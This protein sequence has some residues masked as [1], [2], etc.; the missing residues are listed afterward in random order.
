MREAAEAGA[1]AANV[2]APTSR[3]SVAEDRRRGA[4]SLN[5]RMTVLNA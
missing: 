4:S 2:N 3:A 1:A 5:I